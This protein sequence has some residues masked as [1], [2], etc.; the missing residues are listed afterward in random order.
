M[1]FQT[2]V[3]ILPPILLAITFH[4]YM[5]GY[6]AFRLGDDTAKDM[7]RLTFN[8]LSHLDPIGTLM[9]I[10]VHFGWAKPVPV[11]PYNLRN[12]KKDLIIISAAGPAANICMAIISGILLRIVNSGGLSFL[13]MSVQQPIFTMIYFSLRINIA[14]AFFNLIP[15]PPLDGSKILRG[16]LPR[17]MEHIS[18]WLERYGSFILIG[19]IASSYFTKI[20]IIGI[21]LNP[22][23]QLFSFIFGGV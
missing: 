7:G 19:L 23:I 10:I 9:I 20:S 11:N 8:P 2:I 17:D 21:F 15:I 3:L 6:A 18:D 13:S 4:E 12:P 5:H 16:F 14:L 22:F 1:N